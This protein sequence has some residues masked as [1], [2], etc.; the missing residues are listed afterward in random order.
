MSNVRH[1]MSEPLPSGTSV[2]K[3]VWLGITVGALAQI[4]LKM[5]LPFL[6]L[7][8]VR[9]VSLETENKALWLEEPT[10]S[11]H[12]VWYALQA[13]I[14]AGSVMAGALAAFLAP[15]KALTVPTTLVILSLVATG[16]E[17]FPSNHSSGV[18]LVWSGGPCVG[19]V[20]GI[21]LVWLVARRDA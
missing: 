12:P 13:A 14:F 9:Y 20:L 1:H 11:S 6:V 15:R 4:S 7:V 8:A 16:F 17:Q 10:D 19:L 2:S 3:S 5:L 21:L 18:L